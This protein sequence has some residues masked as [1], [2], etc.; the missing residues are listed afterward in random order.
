M[1]LAI[2]LELSIYYLA[3]RYKKW[4]F[5]FLA[6][7]LPGVFWPSPKARTHGQEYDL[8]YILENQI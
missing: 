2:H 5:V 4:P 3:I 7:R 6:I 1:A 8:K